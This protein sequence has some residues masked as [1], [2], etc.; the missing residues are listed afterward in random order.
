[1]PNY[2]SA[3]AWMSSH[4]HFRFVSFSSQGLIGHGKAHIHT[5][6]SIAQAQAEDA[7]VGGLELPTTIQAFASLGSCGD[8][9][10]SEERD[11]HRWLGRLHGIQVEPYSVRMNLEVG[12]LAYHKCFKLDWTTTSSCLLCQ[13]HFLWLMT[14]EVFNQVELEEV[15]VPILLP[16]E[17]LHAIAM[18]GPEQVGMCTCLL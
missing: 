8:H 7:K 15:G 5:C 16:H 3:N 18:A 13:G 17:V 11:L 2:A 6:V 14:N 12:S 1:M 4:D 10:S 9:A